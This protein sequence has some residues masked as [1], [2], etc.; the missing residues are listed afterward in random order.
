[1]V[2]ISFDDLEIEK[3]GDSHEIACFDCTNKDLN[4]FLNE[5]A[6]YQMNNKL[7]VTYVCKYNSE[8]VAYFTWCSD[9]II[10]KNLEADDK[11]ELEGLGVDYKNLPALKLCRLAVDENCQGNRI[12][13]ELVELTIL[14]AKELSEK[15]GLRFITVDA[16]FKNK[17]LYNKYLFKIFPKEAPKLIKYERNPRPDH[18]IAMYLDFHKE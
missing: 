9:S 2:K 1:M 11:K 12:G 18:T 3:L 10:L 6:H 17:W 8:V 16:Y 15:I 5:E 14:N 7:N 4:E 13:P